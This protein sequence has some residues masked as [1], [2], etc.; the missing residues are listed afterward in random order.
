M[1][2]TPI[3]I[4]LALLSLTSAG[5]FAADVMVHVGH[6]RL[7]PAAVSIA[8]G[9]TVTFHNMDA[10][11]GGHTVATEDGALSS[12]P[13]QK[14]QA[15]SHKFTEP[16]SFGFHIVEHPAAKTTIVVK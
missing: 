13:L 2:W 15:W 1:R 4:A 6:N 5:A 8:V 7:D 9:D 12:P 11:P 3:G 10:M 14:D 16:G